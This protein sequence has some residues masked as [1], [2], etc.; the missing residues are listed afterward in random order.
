MASG[1]FVRDIAV[2]DGWEMQI[3]RF[4][5]GARFPAHTHESPEFLF[6]LDGELVQAGRRMG[7]GWASVAGAGTI[8]EDVY[9]ETGC[10]LSSSIARQPRGAEVDSDIRSRSA[11]DYPP[12][13]RG[14]NRS[15]NPSPSMLKP[16]TASDSAT[17]GQIAS[18]GAWYMWSSPASESMPPH[19]G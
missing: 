14:S 5:P 2:T 18:H 19:V 7:A 6:I 4:E 13:N 11:A 15:R 1:V 12:F 10:V 3:V 9:S 8:D 17:A 16:K